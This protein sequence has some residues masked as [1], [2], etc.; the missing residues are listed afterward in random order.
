MVQLSL[1]R[2]SNIVGKFPLLS[3]TVRTDAAFDYLVKKQ[4]TKKRQVKQNTTDVMHL[5]SMD[6]HP[7]VS[8]KIFVLNRILQQPHILFRKIV[9][10]AHV[11]K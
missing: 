1:Y 9:R 11:H 4:K 5:Q 3:F 2:Y 8:E 10:N 7:L 6:Y